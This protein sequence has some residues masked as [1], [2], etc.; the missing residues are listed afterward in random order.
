[1]L[2]CQTFVRNEKDE[3]ITEPVVQLV[4]EP[5]EADYGCQ[6]YVVLPQA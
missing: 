6:S 1:M 2:Y 4:A 5:D 3:R